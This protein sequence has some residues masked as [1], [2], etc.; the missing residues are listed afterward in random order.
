MDT[1]TA[2]WRAA[3]ADDVPTI[4][5]IAHSIH[6]MH[7]RADV[8]AEKI[9]LFPS[10]CRVL[11]GDGAVCGYALAFPWRLADVPPLDSYLGVLPRDA[12]CIFIYDVAILPAARRRGA[13][14]R[15]VAHA[16]ALAG[17]QGLSRLALVSVYGTYP[18][19]ARRGFEVTP[20]PD[21][22]AK[23]AS[24]GDT[25]CYMVSVIGKR[26]DTV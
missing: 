17:D 11:V 18:F 3:H 22:V 1:T 23:L 21:Q 7:E 10:G 2:T 12:D 14:E 20:L 26:D 24:Y 19:W 13:A 9:A 5:R 8:L 4:D 15:F 16:S 25:A 6:T